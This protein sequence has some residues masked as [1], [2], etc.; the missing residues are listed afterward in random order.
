[1]NRYHKSVLLQEAVTALEVAKD[2]KYID[3]TLGAGGHTKEIL[4]RGGIVL[5]I[6]QDEDALQFVK[7]NFR[8]QIETKTLEVA[9]GNFAEIEEIARERGFTSVSGILFD[10]GVSSH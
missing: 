5:G 10:V 4:E 1:M 2:K 8:M 6:D 3:A 9:R 7:D